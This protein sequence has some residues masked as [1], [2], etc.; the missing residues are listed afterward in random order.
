[1]KRIVIAALAVAIASCMP[2]S[3]Q[4][5]RPKATIGMPGIP[6]VFISALYY[7]AADQKLFEKHG[8]DITLRQFATGT[9][10]TRAV[11][12]GDIEMAMSPTGLVINQISN[13][14]VDLVAIHGYEKPTW[15]LVSYDPSVAKCEDMR[16]KPVA[17]D[18]IGGARSIALNQMLRS[19]NLTANDTQQVPVSANSPA[20]M[21]AGQVQLAVLHLDELPTVERQASKKLAVVLDVNQII[22]VNHYLLLTTTRKRVAEQRDLFVRVIAALIEAQRYMSDPK[23]LDQIA[24]AVAPTGRSAEDARYAVTEYL[25]IEFW[26]K[27][28]AGL[29]KPKLEA[30]VATQKRVGAIRPEATPV[31][32]ERLAD[33][34]LWQDAVK[35]VK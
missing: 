18:T 7:V 19:C 13:A 21:I 25:K 17:V 34:S 27:D 16:G 11:I 2:V 12:A 29:A 32:Y 24:K 6:P 1:M 23:N 33:T 28:S 22:P 5:Q 4:A 30:V 14:N 31:S 3:A 10:A 35:L 15:R 8:V 26:P 20:A 9:D